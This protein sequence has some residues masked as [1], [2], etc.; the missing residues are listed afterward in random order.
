MLMYEYLRALSLDRSSLIRT[1]ELLQNFVFG[2]EYMLG[3]HLVLI[4]HGVLI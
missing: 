2:S 3:G 4:Y 1:T